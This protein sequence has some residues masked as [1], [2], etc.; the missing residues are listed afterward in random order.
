M[1]LP[2]P[3]CSFLGSFAQEDLFSITLSPEALGWGMNGCYG[4]TIV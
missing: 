2:G 1:S 3:G 4:N